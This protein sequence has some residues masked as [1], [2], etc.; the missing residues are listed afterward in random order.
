M[1]TRL[2]RPALFRHFF[3][4]ALLISFQVYL[5]YGAVNGRFGLE[6]QGEMLAEIEDMQ[7]ETSVL[8]AQIDAYRH[9]ISL[10]DPDRLDPDIINEK[11]RELLSMADPD[12][13]IVVLPGQI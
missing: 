6:S 2:K 1:T 5:G 9:R 10:F 12:D 7:K 4:G 13:I 8:Q 11:A 3:I